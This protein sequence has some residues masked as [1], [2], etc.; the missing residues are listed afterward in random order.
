VSDQLRKKRV[1]QETEKLLRRGE[2]MESRT[3]K[4]LTDLDRYR[5]T[6]PL[7][8]EGGMWLKAYALAIATH[9]Y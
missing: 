5:D 6:L 8:K 7:C 3:H 1:I 4:L 9:R 2:G